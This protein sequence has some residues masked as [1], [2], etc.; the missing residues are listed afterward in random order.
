MLPKITHGLCQRCGA[1][2]PL[3]YI[4][5]HRHVGMLVLM[6]HTTTRAHLCR[7]CIGAVY[8]SHTGVTAL[9]GWWG[10][11]SFFV[12]PF[13]LIY[14]TI[15]YLMALSLAAPV[16]PGFEVVVSSPIEAK[17]AGQPPVASELILEAPVSTAFVPESLRSD[18]AAEDALDPALYAPTTLCKGMRFGRYSVKRF[19]QQRLDIVRSGGLP[20]WLGWSGLGCVLAS[21]G[22]LAVPAMLTF[23]FPGLLL[24]LIAYSCLRRFRLQSPQGVCVGTKS[25]SINEFYAVY[26]DLTERRCPQLVLILAERM[27]TSADGGVLVAGCDPTDSEAPNMVRV[28]AAIAVRTGLPLRATPEARRACGALLK[29]SEEAMPLILEA[30][31]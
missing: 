25:W 12:T 18:V 26:L 10:I 9:A 3:K 14:N 29:C 8:W 28:A 21:V 7:N 1:V 17:G 23:L 5:F 13:V 24:L 31:Q 4:E 19:S 11:I 15:K 2:A 27:P 16:G 22:S 20:R 6:H 30:A